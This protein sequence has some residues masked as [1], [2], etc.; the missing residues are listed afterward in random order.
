MWTGGYL[1][2][3]RLRLCNTVYDTETVFTV[4][5]RKHRAEVTEEKVLQRVWKEPMS[6]SQGD[7]NMLVL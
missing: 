4:G 2:H 1:C 7:E 6:S 5:S 3:D